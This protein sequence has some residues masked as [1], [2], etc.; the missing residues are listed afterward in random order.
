MNENL[1]SSN[2]R[3]LVID[4]NQAIHSDFHKIFRVDLES[5][6]ALSEAEYALFGDE[7]ESVARPVFQID[8]AFQ[9]QEGLARV[10][11][12]R[13]EGRPY[14]VAFVDVRMPPGWDGV[15]TT[16]QI[17]RHDPDVQIVICTA[18]SDYSWDEMLD[19]LGA[20]DR[21]VILKKPF[22]N[23]EV[24]QLA[25]ALTE[26]WR[27]AQQAKAQVENLERSVEERTRDLLATNSQLEATNQKLAAATR[28]ANEMAAAAEVASKAKSEF[29][30]NMSHEIR[31]PMNGII[32]MT[33]L[34]LDTEVTREQR[35]YLTMVRDS[36][37]SL[38]AVINGILDFSKIEA[39]HM[40]LET[41]PF[42][43][44]AVVAEAVRSLGLTAET[45]GLELSFRIA[46]DLPDQLL[47]DAGR[48]RQVVINLVSNAIKFTSAG[49]V[50]V[51]LKMEWLQDGQAALHATVRDTGI[52][53]PSNRLEHIFE[54]FTQADGS[55]TRRFGGTGLGLT[56]SSQ[57]A[58]LM[59]G[60]MWVESEIGRGSVFHFTACFGLAEYE[61]PLL[62]RSDLASLRGLRVLVVDDQATNQ[63]ILEELLR[64]WGLE[65][66]CVA[67]G[68]TAL[69]TLAA[70]REANR[71]FQLVVL[72][73]RM[74][75]LSGFEVAARIHEEPALAPRTVMMLSS[76]GLAEEAVR[77]REM[78][79][80][81]YVVKPVKASHLLDAIRTA[82]MPADAV[83]AATK[84]VAVAPRRARSLRVLLAE[85]NLVNQCLVAA[86]LKKR[87]HTVDLA[88]TGRAVLAAIQANPPD[89][90]L[91]DV[92]MPEM[93]GFEAT[94]AIRAAEAGTDRHLPI[95]ALTAHAL[96][97]DREACLA[98]GMDDY[99]AKPIRG[100]ALI[101]MVERLA[102]DATEAAAVETAQS[103]GIGGGPSGT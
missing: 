97:G 19:K 20:S 15:E 63:R 87:G 31:T 12:A 103:R 26:K 69:A 4:D 23:I 52:G 6:T 95:V 28:R 89:L 38:L 25:N 75:D 24:L 79:G 43:L 66:T 56:I 30:A 22:D 80:V 49:E 18:Y 81:P 42:S 88:M 46:P 53:I 71:A 14:A 16:G 62:E 27:L 67:N 11:Q 91:M 100:S 99:L 59:G 33:E 34:L 60:R 85:D 47:G 37:D 84:K 5:D 83:S 92:Q 51:D 44:R 78:G 90:V 10:C 93:D 1:P 21:L 29:L 68:E 13:E 39:G 94:A 8:S 82:L 3:M 32:G 35:D 77:C 55:T 9:G 73:A 54:P 7:P 45:K 17:W 72:D 57:L 36:A 50:V 65:V 96:K 58:A 48:L 86:M 2:R 102:G 101:A 74:P 40:E 76:S 64:D 41:F 98:A 61:E 70:E